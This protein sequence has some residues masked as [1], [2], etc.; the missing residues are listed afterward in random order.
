MKSSVDT[1]ERPPGGSPTAGEVRE[2]LRELCEAQPFR[3][4]PRCIKFLNYVVEETLA[5]RKDNLKERSIGVA[6]F[7]RPP[8][9]DSEAD[10]VVRQVAVD[11][12]R[13]L[14]QFYAGPGSHHRLR[15]DVPYGS[16]AAVFR[17][18]E[19][20]SPRQAEPGLRKSRRVWAYG[21]G[22][23][24]VIGAV[25]IAIGLWSRPAPLDLF[26]EPVLR[27][28]PRIVLCIGKGAGFR[29]ST[30]A[31]PAQVGSGAGADPQANRRIERE[32]NVHAADAVVLSRLSAFFAQGNKTVLARY[33]GQ[34]TFAELRE[35]PA[36]L[37]GA[38]NNEWSLKLTGDFRYQ[39][40]FR[41]N[42]R[43]EWVEDTVH[44][45]NRWGLSNIPTDGNIPEDYAIVTRVLNPNTGRMLVVLGG[46]TY[47]ATL[48]AGEFLTN[49]EVFRGALPAFPRDW[50]RKNLQVVLTT[51]VTANVNGPPRVIAVHVW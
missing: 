30:A 17:A 45:E 18:N 41:E 26:W 49:P 12:R 48:A 15:I 1:P 40:R 50:S 42:G 3:T 20:A 13:R 27:D 8:D 5:G 32:L 21:A 19:P 39:F 4:S 16:Y 43:E 46:L 6:A 47:H 9:Y 44:P 37:I 25:A 51:K 31:A 10:P 7:N 11:V 23:A 35:N 22:A 33:V 36:V 28:H 14:L 38:F 24:A 34:L 2:H 29:S